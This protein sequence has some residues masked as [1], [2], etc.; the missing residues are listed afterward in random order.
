MTVLRM[1]KRELDR[2]ETLHRVCDRRLSV[3]DAAEAMN[4]TRRHA[5]RLLG[6]Y[7][8]HGTSGLMSKRRG[9]PSNRRHTDAF[10]DY[11]IELIRRHYPDFGPTLA[12][13]KLAE[14]H[15]VTVSKETV[16]QWMNEAGLWQSRAERR[17]RVQQPRQ[18]RA[19]FGE[20]VQIDGSLHWWFEDRGPKC[21]LIVFIDD[22]TGAILH[23]RFC[24]S[25]STFDCLQA[26]EASIG[27]FG[28]PL[29]SYSDRH[30]IFRT[31]KVAEKT[32]GEHNG[33]TQFGRAL[34]ELDVAPEVF[35]LI[36]GLCSCCGP[37]GALLQTR[38]G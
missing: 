36:A 35:P 21:A 23:L 12:S 7:R 34:N 14:R 1:S 28:K 2:A 37:L 24:P 33:M 29:A 5:S 38:S 4:V 31:V 3:T 13:E 10:R 26:A 16:R 17:K 25:E 19:R 6:A 9:K 30:S 20:L 32:D 15:A 8:R 27:R 22:A 11:V 18:R